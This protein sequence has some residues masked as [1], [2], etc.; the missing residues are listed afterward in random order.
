[1][2]ELTTQLF[3][4]LKGVWKYRW[5]A[6]VAAWVI[7]IAGWVIVYKLPDDYQASARIYV[8]TQNVLKPLMAGMTISPDLQQQVSIMSRTLI[9]RPNVERV[10]RMVDLDIKA[11]D[12]KDQEKLVKGL[13]DNIKLGATGRDNLFTIHYNNQ[14]PK[15]AKDVVQ[16]LLTIFVEGGL[17]DKKDSSSAIRFIDEQIQSY[18]EK[19]MAGENNLKAFKQKNIGMMPQQGS[20]YYAQLSLASEDLNK[21]RLD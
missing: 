7:A 6:V 16:S 2:E 21:T 19:L 9:S 8:D 1:M 17:G 15:L 3:V 12:V 13:M 10:V 20:D 14:N 18:E 11:K 4:Y 5:I